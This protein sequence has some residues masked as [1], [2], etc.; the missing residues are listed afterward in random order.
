MNSKLQPA[1][2][3]SE[4]LKFWFKLGFISFGGPAGQ[5]A[6]MHKELVEER[7]WISEKRFL[8]ALNYCMVLPGPEAQQL[9]I[10]IGWLLH[11]TWGGVVAGVLFVLP[12]LVYFDWFELR[13]RGVWQCAVGGGVAVWH[14]TSSSGYCGASGT[15]HWL[16]NTQNA[17]NC[18]DIVGSCCA[19]FFS[20]L[21]FANAFSCD[22]YL[23]CFDWCFGC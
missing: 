22:C 6:I 15:P 2:P 10:Y 20:Y 5:I 14:Q 17:N 18:A 16:Q 9:A 19:E 12:S 4:A 23:R 8:H 1:V 7:R 11:R 3:F 21:F 13:L